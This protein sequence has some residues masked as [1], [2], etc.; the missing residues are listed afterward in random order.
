MA[1]E[2]DAPGAKTGGLS[3]QMAQQ[4]AQTGSALQVVQHPVT[5]RVTNALDVE[6]RITELSNAL[7]RRRSK[8]HTPLIAEAWHRA[9]TSTGLIKKYPTVP[10]GIQF[11]FDAGIQPIT[12]T[13]TPPNKPSI[14]VHEDE[15][16][17]IVEKEFARGRY[18]G[19][20]SKA[21]TESLIGP[22]Q[23]SPLD[24]TPKTGSTG[25]YRLVQNFSFPHSPSDGVYSINHAIDSDLFPCTWGTFSIICLLISRLPPGSE[26][27]VRDVAEAYRT[28]PVTSPQWPGL[29]VK[30]QGEDNYAIDTTDCFGLSSSAGTYGIV[31]DA[32]ADIARARG[33][34]PM[35]K[36]VDDH[37]FFRIRKE[38]IVEYNSYRRNWGASI[39]ANGGRLHEGGRLWY[40]GDTMPDGRPE[41]FD[42][43]SSTSLHDFSLSSPRS[44]ADQSFTY[45]M[46]DIDRVYTE[47]GV[48][49]ETS[50][51][52]P[53]ATSVPFIGFIWDIANHQVSI[54]DKKKTKYIAAIREWQTQPTHTLEEVRKLYGK[55]L[56][57]CLV[58]PAGRA[59]LTNLETLLSIFHDR[60]FMPR[61]SPRDTSDDLI[62]WTK[63]LSQPNVFRTIPGPQPITDVDAYSDASSTTGIGITI[64]RKWRAWRLLPGW[65]ADGRD[66]GW[67]EAV[68]FEFVTDTLLAS[69]PRGGHLKIYGDNRGVVEGWWKGKSRNKPTNTVFKRIH[70][71]TSSVA[72]TIHS[73]YVASKANP[74]DG[75]SRG[76]YPPRSDLLPPIPIPFE[77][78]DLVADF[79]AELNAT[80]L[81][82]HREGNM[83]KPVPKSLRDN[84]NDDNATS[85]HDFERREQELRQQE[86]GW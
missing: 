73:R 85:H 51:D 82:L 64:G 63:T 2:L 31:S 37:I 21:E 72:C 26:A 48:P 27:A 29:V 40:R 23:S 20:L 52:V 46:E 68:G 45:N 59:Y 78:R 49:W 81:R 17:K 77:L 56:H 70:Q 42:E 71:K 1:Q 4:Y 18:I 11:G 19:P 33:I 22:F 16:T 12:R 55:L 39:A 60:P 6:N 13:F 35:S 50:K 24:L 58:I 34:G 25:K 8:A 41:E 5:T 67:A 28:I 79:D 15:F 9:L 86:E 10:H 75:P 3:T 32:G 65:K 47:L 66:I 53:F 38:Y 69:H 30:L 14:M 84:R 36:W 7:E 74:A 83:P 61:T 44:D 54:P 43:D 62:W 76:I 80:E 57:A